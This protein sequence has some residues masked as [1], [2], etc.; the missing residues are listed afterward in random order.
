MK[1]AVQQFLLHAPA[2]LSMAPFEDSSWLHVFIISFQSL[3]KD[4][5]DYNA[6]NIYLNIMVQ[7]AFRTGEV[8][9]SSDLTGWTLLF[10]FFLVYLIGHYFVHLVCR[11]VA[12]CTAGLGLEKDL[13]PPSIHL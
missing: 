3:F 7:A 11:T 13:F 9:S 1:L 12:N 2:S 5:I 8:L 6:L 4:S 10:K